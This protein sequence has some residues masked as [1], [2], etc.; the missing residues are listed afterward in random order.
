LGTVRVHRRNA[1]H[2]LSISSQGQLFALALKAISSSSS[3]EGDPLHDVGPWGADKIGAGGPIM[4]RLAA[5][6]G[7]APHSGADRA[8][9]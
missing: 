2:K 8:G 6:A 3:E 7:A 1:Y 4:M 5:P 9:P